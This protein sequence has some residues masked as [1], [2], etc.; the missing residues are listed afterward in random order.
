MRLQP[1]VWINLLRNAFIA[2]RLSPSR[3]LLDAIPNYYWRQDWV[4]PAPVLTVDEGRMQTC[5]GEAPP[6]ICDSVNHNDALTF[7]EAVR[8]SIYPYVANYI[9]SY[10]PP[11]EVPHNSHSI[12]PVAEDRRL[13]FLLAMITPSFSSRANIQS[14]LMDKM[15][16][17]IEINLN[18]DMLPLGSLP[19]SGLD[20]NRLAALET[21]YSFILSDMFGNASVLGWHG[22]RSALRVLLATYDFHES[23]SPPVFRPQ[24]VVYAS[25]SD[26]V[27][28]RRL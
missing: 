24:Q 15:M 21:L 23:T 19:C 14:A 22:Q 11:A 10:R 17:Y 6:F 2:S 13:Q 16:E 28:S 3:G 9:I 8:S 25:R 20:S 7:Q 1:I 5:H 12:L 27:N 4:C 26:K 18:V